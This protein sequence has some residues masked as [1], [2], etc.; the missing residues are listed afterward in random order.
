MNYS[1]K[2]RRDGT[3]SETARRWNAVY[4]LW[5]SGHL[6][7]EVREDRTEDGHHASSVCGDFRDPFLTDHLNLYD[8]HGQ[9][10]RVGSVVR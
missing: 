6:P 4:Y 5:T 10:L 1:R 2:S 9:S 8:I 3:G 7:E